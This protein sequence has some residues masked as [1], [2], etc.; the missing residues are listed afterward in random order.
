MQVVTEI[1]RR[2]DSDFDP[3]SI[4]EASGRKA[5]AENK[6]CKSKAVK[7]AYNE[8]TLRNVASQYS[9]D[10]IRFGYM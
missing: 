8:D 5:E 4:S 1:N 10:V 9:L 2:S 7:K 3:E 6:V